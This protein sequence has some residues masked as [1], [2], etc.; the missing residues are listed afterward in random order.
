[1]KKQ[2]L[3]GAILLSG[4]FLLGACGSKKGNEKADGKKEEQTLIIGASPS[5]HA[6]ILEQA[7]PLLEKEGVKLEIKEF[8]DYV[9]P[10]TTLVEGDIDANYFAH[11]PFINN[12]NKENGD[13]LGIAGAVHLEPLGLYSKNYK[14]IKDVK[15]GATVIASTNVPD[16]GR[17]L[18]ILEDAKL[19]TVKDGV[20]RETAT[21]DDIKD[22]PKHLKF[23]Y[24]VAPEMMTSV[25]KNN[26]GDL[27]A[28][29][30]NFA[31]QVGLN[32]LKDA[33][34]IDADDSPY[35]NVIATRKGEEKD[36]RVQKLIKVLHDKTIQ[37]W[38]VKK[39]EGSVKPVPA[40][41][42]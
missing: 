30:S 10:D 26:E 12:Y 34:L 31:Y 2:I 6:E 28:I 19:I 37:D 38:I 35:V 11:V 27:I 25:Y 39:W 41:V 20:D 29:N 18:T 1:M 23:K 24:D 3:T 36:E 15:D 14:D 40:E 21:F 32:P 4:L 16:Y 13:K 7:K 33:L 5:P 42:K 8:T 22:N 17:I 9:L